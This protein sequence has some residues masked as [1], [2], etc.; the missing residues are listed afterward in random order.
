[1]IS[2]ARRKLLDDFRLKWGANE[3]I[4][5]ADQVP[6]RQA[7]DQLCDLANALEALQGLYHQR[8][9]ATVY[10]RRVIGSVVDALFRNWPLAPLGLQSEKGAMAERKTDEHDPPI[11]FFRDLLMDSDLRPSQAEWQYILLKHFRVVKICTTENAELT[12]RRWKQNRPTDA[13]D[14]C[15]IQLDAESS[16]REIAHRTATDERIAQLLGLPSNGSPP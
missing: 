9:G 3:Y 13:Y 11:S 12:K 7:L 16:A 2:E 14:L 4:R 10:T 6:E 5:A 8:G 1:M 15:G